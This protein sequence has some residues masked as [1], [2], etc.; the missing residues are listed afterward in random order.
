MGRKT[1]PKF[2][3]AAATRR[4]RSESASTVRSRARSRFR[5]PSP[6]KA[7]CPSLGDRYRSGE[8]PEPHDEPRPRPDGDARPTHDAVRPCHA[9]KGYATPPHPRTRNASPRCQARQKAPKPQRGPRS[10]SG[11]SQTPPGNRGLS[12]TGMPPAASP[13]ILSIRRR[14]PDGGRAGRHGKGAVRPTAIR[15]WWTGEAGRR[16]NPLT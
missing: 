11:P 5:M 1:L 16:Q 7:M 10:V 8:R 2:I 14:L 12:R 9:R 6:K 15:V 3:V 13:V 4:R